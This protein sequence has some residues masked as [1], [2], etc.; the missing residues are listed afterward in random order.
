MQSEGSVLVYLN[1]ICGIV[2]VTLC[3]LTSSLLIIFLVLSLLSLINGLCIEKRRLKRLDDSLFYYPPDD[4]SPKKIEELLLLDKYQGLLFILNLIAF[5]LFWAL[6]FI[7]IE[8]EGMTWSTGIAM[9]F[10]TL[11]LLFDFTLF[12]KELT[13]LTVSE[14]SKE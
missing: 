13:H 4:L 9:M 6:P 2:F 8:S 14:S 7:R 3:V 11:V 5:F 10:F 1:A 12:G